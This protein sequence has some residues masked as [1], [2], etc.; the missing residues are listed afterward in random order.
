MRI[1]KDISW[2]LSAAAV[3]QAKREYTLCLE[4]EA[5]W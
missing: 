2:D 4:Q 5:A 1:T 3:P